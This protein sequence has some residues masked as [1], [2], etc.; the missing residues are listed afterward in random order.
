MLS[1]LKARLLLACVVLSA[2][3]GAVQ[4]QTPAVS[5]SVRAAAQSSQEVEAV[6]LLD[7]APEAAQERARFSAVTSA[8]QPVLADYQAM[9]QAREAA[10]AS[11]KDAVLRSVS[12]ADLQLLSSYS[13][14]PILHVRLSSQA[15]LDRLLSN[16]RVK[17]VDEIISVQPNLPESLPVVRQPTAAAGGRTG[18]GTTV[19]VLDTGVDFARAAFGSC[20]APGGACKVAVALDF[21]PND[22][23]RDDSSL[24]GT[25]VAGIVLGVAPGA[26]IAALD[27]FR[28]DG[29]AYSPDLIAAINW[30]VVNKA[31]YNIASLNM[32][33]GGGRY[34]SPLAPTDSFGVALQSA[35]NAGIVI[36]VS[37]GNDTFTDSISWPAAYS[38]VVSVGAVYDSNLGGIGWSRCSDFTTAVDRVTC[39]SNSASFLTMLAPGAL[40]SSAGIVMGGTSQA[41]PHVAGAAAVLRAAFPSESVS[42]LTTRLRTGPNVLDGRNGIIKPRLDL[43]AALGSGLGQNLTVSKAGSGS[44]TVTSSPT[45]INCGA[46]CS[47]S[48]ATGTTVT[49]SASAASGSSFA[50]WSGACSGTGSCVVS[51]TA[52]RSVTATFNTTASFTLSV[53][54]TGT[55]SGTVTSSPAGINCGADCSEPYPSGTSVTLTPAASAGSTFAGWSGACTG[56]GACVVSMTAARSVTATFNT[57]P[58][59]TLSVSKSGTGSGTVSSSPAGISCGADCTESYVSGTSVT[60]TPTAASGS[61][62]AGWSGA[63][64]GT[65]ACVV[66]MT[67]ARSVT[68]SFNTLPRFTLSVSKS[69]TGSGTVSSSPAGINCGADC[70]ESY[71]S[72]TSVTLTP[73]AATGSTFAGWSGACT[74]TGACVVSMTAARSVTATFNLAPVQVNLSVLRTGSGSVTSSPSGINCSTSGATCTRSF[75]QGSSVTLTAAP[76]SGWVFR[77]WGGACT[78]TTA[79]CTVSMNASKSVTAT[80]ASTSLGSLGTALE[81]PSLPWA[82]GGATAS[83][84]SWFVEPLGSAV[85]G[86]AGRSGVISH[87]G[88]TSLRTTVTGPGLLQFR[89]QVESEAGFD[90]LVF[91]VNGWEQAAISGASGWVELSWVIPAGM[92]TLNWVYRKDLS[93][94]VGADK[95]NLDNVRFTALPPGG[96]PSGP[97]EARAV[98]T[99]DSGRASD[100]RIFGPVTPK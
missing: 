39:F 22:G 36:A 12:G 92:H 54:R 77:G 38:N 62:F 76:A 53:S 44:G 2:C 79:T 93:A 83:G 87:N 29:L 41:A 98:V 61:T 74:G 6:I 37:S 33:L 94:S 72:G 3:A 91:E 34:Y 21:A 80:F 47:E 45:G 100:R 13:A 14:L 4:A 81:A 66:S 68:A 31:A 30:V 43:V 26:R 75:N 48:Y 23:L 56:T 70:T 7:D 16:P 60:L 99:P 18:A 86:S 25:N 95:G 73:A 24:H 42:A 65:G 51:M 1:R 9:I 19:A 64:T 63:C 88:S 8:A 55:G 69:G 82:S 78:V 49:L 15:A 85:G 52:A 97:D 46:D 35:V 32:S 20:S 50:G 11:M 27:V 67:A 5:P 17:S 89:W 90:W 57:L 59:F 40:I 96:L 28:S 58:R 10:L 84:P 71:L